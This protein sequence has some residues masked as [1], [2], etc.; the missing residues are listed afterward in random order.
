MQTM[1]YL[2][3]QIVAE[4]VS[5]RDDNFEDIESCKVYVKIVLATVI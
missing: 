1:K 3:R 4:A 2:S 5:N